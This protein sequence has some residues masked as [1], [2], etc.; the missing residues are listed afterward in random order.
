[1][2]SQTAQQIITIHGPI[3]LE[4]KATRQKFGQLIQH[5]MRNNFFEK[6]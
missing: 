3:S 2:T 6:S 5:N 1:M 4:V